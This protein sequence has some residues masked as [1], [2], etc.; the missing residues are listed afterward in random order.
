M[1]FF[2]EVMILVTTSIRSWNGQLGAYAVNLSFLLS[3]NFFVRRLPGPGLSALGI[4]TGD[5]F[6][7]SLGAIDKY[8]GERLGT[9][10]FVN[11]AP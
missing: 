8:Y 6:G 3:H 1:P 9:I 4:Q 2:I 10:A 11:R 7:S 5:I